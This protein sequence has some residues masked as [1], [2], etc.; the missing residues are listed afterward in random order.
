[1]LDLDGP[2]F[3][4]FLSGLEERGCEVARRE[5]GC[6]FEIDASRNRRD[7]LSSVL[8]LPFSDHD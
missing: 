5:R 8:P 7:H 6:D 3:S 4:L 1:M 2:Y